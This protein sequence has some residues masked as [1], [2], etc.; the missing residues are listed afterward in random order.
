MLKN[1]NYITFL[2][3]TMRTNH[4]LHKQDKE[5]RNM[6]SMNCGHNLGQK[7]IFSKLIIAIGMVF[8]HNVL[9][10]PEDI[11]LGPVHCLVI[12]SFTEFSVCNQKF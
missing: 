4:S 10:S 3:I 1:Y 2:Q 8:R 12:R 6:I 7:A 5:M 11:P 9:V